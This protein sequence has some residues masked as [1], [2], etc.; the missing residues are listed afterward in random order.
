MI[1]KKRGKDLIRL[2]E[3][4]RKRE[5][6]RSSIEVVICQKIREECICCKLSL[7]SENI[8][9][10]NLLSYYS[11]ILFFIK[12]IRVDTNECTVHFRGT[13]RFNEIGKKRAYPAAENPTGADLVF[14]WF[15]LLHIMISVTAF[16][17]EFLFITL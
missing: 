13:K 17:H 1:L 5:R 12:L 3:K 10:K 2:R 11:V 6:E 4:E 16:A 9:F 8:A 15:I 7:Y 14:L